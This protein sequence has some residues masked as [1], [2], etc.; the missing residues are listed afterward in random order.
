LEQ[1]LPPKMFFGTKSAAKNVLWNKI[2]TP[3][4]F[5]G[6]KSVAAKNVL[7]NKI[8][9]PSQNVPKKEQNLQF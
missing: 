5:F 2:D 8:G 7:W 1:N 3:K 9:R 6:T 4:M